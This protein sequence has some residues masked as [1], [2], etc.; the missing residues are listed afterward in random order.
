MNQ[1]LPK[2]HQKQ[3]FSKKKEA[4]KVYK[5]IKGI[6]EIYSFMITKGPE[7]N[8]YGGDKKCVKCMSD[9]WWT[10]MHLRR[11]ANNLKSRQVF[12]ETVRKIRTN[13]NQ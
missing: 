9:T 1:I 5:D 6:K 4:A 7:Y 12:D 13:V 2:L 8:T 3:K 10:N 11:V